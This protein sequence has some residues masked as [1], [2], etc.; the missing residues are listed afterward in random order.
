[1]ADEPEAKLEAIRRELA[2]MNEHMAQ[3]V[4]LLGKILRELEKRN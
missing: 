3:V 4:Q 1:M 2:K